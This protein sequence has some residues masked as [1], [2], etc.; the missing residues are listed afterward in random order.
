[1]TPEWA[2]HH[3]GVVARAVVVSLALGVV[4]T[5]ISSGGRRG[6]IV[7]R[8]RSTGLGDLLELD[9]LRRLVRPLRSGRSR[10]GYGWNPCHIDKASA[11]VSRGELSIGGD[12]LR[13]F[14]MSV[15]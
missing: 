13:G 10:H 14:K 11:D 8:R 5:A 4:L 1:M 15:R 9:A 3:F 12:G 2:W 7:G 6:E